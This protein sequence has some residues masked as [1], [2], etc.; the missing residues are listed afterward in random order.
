MNAS[1]EDIFVTVVVVI[2][3]GYSV[4]ETY[5]REASLFSGVF[6]VAFSIVFEEP[7]GIPRGSLFQRPDIGAI[8]EEN[9]QIA[10]VV[11]VE[12]R[13]PPAIASGACRTFPQKNTNKPSSPCSPP[14]P[15]QAPPDLSAALFSSLFCSLCPL[16]SSLCDLCV[17]VLLFSS[18]E[19]STPPFPATLSQTLPGPH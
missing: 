3:D 2:A 10:V 5:P 11:I 1:H 16:C 18:P 17:T 7:V 6:E 13:H 8:G 4:V 15:T 19:I 14:L 9:I 12:N